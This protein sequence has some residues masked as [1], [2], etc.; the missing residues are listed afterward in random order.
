MKINFKCLQDTLLEIVNRQPG[1]L[2][3]GVGWRHQLKGCQH[4]NKFLKLKTRGV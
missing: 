4:A 1:V 2:R 3:R